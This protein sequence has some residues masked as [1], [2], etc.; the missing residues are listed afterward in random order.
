M[1]GRTATHEIRIDASR[2]VVTKRFRSWDRREPAREWTTLML[3]AEF[4]PGL[5]PSPVRADLA[6]DPPLIEMSWLPGVPLGDTT[7]SAAQ[8][9]A[10]A[11]AL[12]RLWNAVP[13][14]RLKNLNW[15]VLNVSQLERRVTEMLAAH[16]AMDDRGLVRQAWQAGAGWFSSGTR[17]ASGPGSMT[18]RNAAAGTARQHSIPQSSADIA[19]TRMPSYSSVGAGW[20]AR[21]LP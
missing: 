15:P 17:A 7:P 4:A 16:P 21:I 20:Q 9:D 6:A 5:A 1:S 3:L 8:A 14:A 2:G 11:L 19:A 10:L 18:C 13:R 12:D